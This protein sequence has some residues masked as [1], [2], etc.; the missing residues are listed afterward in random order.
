MASGCRLG[1]IGLLAGCEVVGEG[2]RVLC[3]RVGGRSSCGTGMHGVAVIRMSILVEHVA[4]DLEVH[5][6]TDDLVPA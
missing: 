4:V 3:A 5:V 6:D 1:G 2:H